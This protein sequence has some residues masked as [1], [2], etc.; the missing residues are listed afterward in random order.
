MPS[1]CS[2]KRDCAA[3]RKEPYGR[4]GMPCTSGDATCYYYRGAYYKAFW[5]DPPGCAVGEPRASYL[6]ERYFPLVL[7]NVH[8]YGLL[9]SV[10][11]LFILGW[12]ALKAFR[13]DDG[14][15]GTTFGMGL[16][17]AIMVVNVVLLSCYTFGCHSTR[18]VLGG[19]SDTLS[20]SRV[21][22]VAYDCSSCLNRAHMRWAWFSL[23]SVAFTDVY[24]RPAPWVSGRM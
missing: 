14:V 16:G 11:F 12:D 4:A 15:G 7:Q 9:L 23:F 20:S 3:K 22:K 13:F 24:I 2:R 21:R 1:C 19:L 8:R 6:G 18:H 10:V 5:Q 17:T